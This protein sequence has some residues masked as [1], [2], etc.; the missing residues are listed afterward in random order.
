MHS[1]TLK[2]ALAAAAVSLTMAGAV[3]GPVYAQ[4]DAAL[5]EM[6]FDQAD[7]LLMEANLAKANILAP[8][9]YAKAAE[10]YRSA[11]ERLSD[12]GNIETIRKDLAKASAAFTSAKEATQLAVVT[13]SSVLEARDDAA[14][15][16]A[17]DFAGALWQDAELEFAEASAKLEDGNVNTAK[18]SGQ[19]AE[20]L[21]REAELAAVKANYLDETR[22]LIAQAKKEKVKKY[23]PVTLQNAQDLLDKAE[24]ALSENRYDT[25]EPRN[26]ARRAKDEALHAIYLASILKPVKDKDVSLEAFALAAEKP[27]SR[28]ASEV[29]LVARFDQGYAPVAD[30]VI[31]RIGDLQSM[32]N[33]NTDRG[34]Q[35]IDLKEEIAT[36]EGELG[37]Q[38]DRL[39]AQEEQRARFK[40]L[41]NM[42]DAEDAEIFTQGQS[43]LI[44]L[45]GLNF[46]P[47]SSQIEADYFGVLRKVQNAIRLFPEMSVAIEGHT[48]SFGSDALNLTLSED[49]AASVRSYLLANMDDISESV[50]SAIGYGEARPVANNESPDGRARNRRID[51][52]LVPAS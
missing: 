36:L 19:K 45:T 9:T 49:R 25:D 31:M 14:A 27:M 50:V 2:Q 47:G 23:A 18:S 17:K 12:G 42:F 32:A 33:E 24:T 43:V 48:D 11:N 44:R 21:Y 41:D 34:Y 29:D 20:D 1:S 39:L 6:L 51:V 35:I 37:K 38:S 10:Y 3:A 26:L 52:V 5:R 30:G 13:F 7:T 8:Q 46:N 22:R 16:N 28:I 4:Q 40:Q 15:A